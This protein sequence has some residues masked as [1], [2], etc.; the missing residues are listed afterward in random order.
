[1]TLLG[2][3]LSVEAGEPE[4]LHCSAR[5]RTVIKR[6]GPLSRERLL[7]VR[8]IRS[9]KRGNKDPLQPGWRPR[10]SDSPSVH[11]RAA[12]PLTTTPPTPPHSTTIH[13]RRKAGQRGA[14]V[15]EWL[16]PS[17]KPIS[18]DPSPGVL[19][20][21]GNQNAAPVTA[22]RNPA[23]SHH[24][25]SLLFVDKAGRG[26]RSHLGAGKFLAGLSRHFSAVQTCHFSHQCIM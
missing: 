6:R 17:A 4:A 25:T 15:T 23:I 10:S 22:I 18:A 16:F 11:W 20:Y 12:I 7:L 8:A 13:H 21:G 3:K 1:M 9:R 2:P 26:E 14:A 5:H 24:P 19:A